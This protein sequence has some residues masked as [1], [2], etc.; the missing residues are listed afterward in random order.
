M[1]TGN[2]VGR[3]EI[4]L[5]LLAVGALIVFLGFLTEAPAYAQAMDPTTL[6]QIPGCSWYLSA[7][8]PGIYESWCGSDEIGWYRPYEWYLLTGYYPPAYGLGGG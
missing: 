5:L 1:M 6:P 3:R 2:K 4:R 8:F 7:Q